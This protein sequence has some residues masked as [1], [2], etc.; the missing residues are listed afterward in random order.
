MV[1]GFQQRQE[2]LG[3]TYFTVWNFRLERRDASGQPLPPI[4]VEMKGRFF[5]GA[6]NN[7]DI[8]DIGQSYRQG[9]LVTTQ[10]VRNVTVGVDVVAVGRQHRVLR[11]IGITI[12]AII[13]I[14]IFGLILTQM[15]NIAT[16]ELPDPGDLNP[17]FP[18]P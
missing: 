7:G 11:N 10:R 17:E 16:F 18:E 13:A 1:N 2:M 8:V 9:E 12:F 6:I 4:P 14:C 3:R 15:W 5:K